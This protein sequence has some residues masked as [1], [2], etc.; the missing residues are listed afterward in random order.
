MNPIKV[1]ERKSQIIRS[2]HV[3]SL[4]REYVSGVV[5]CHRND[6]YTER[7]PK[8]S[9]WL[10]PLLSGCLRSLHHTD[11]RFRDAQPQFPPIRNQLHSWPLKNAGELKRLPALVTLQGDA[12]ASQLLL[13]IRLE[14][15]DDAAD[16]VFDA[17]FA[18][19]SPK[20]HGAPEGAA[21]GLMRFELPLCVSGQ[22]DEVVPGKHLLRG[23]THKAREGE[24]LLQQVQLGLNGKCAE[25]RL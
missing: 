18:H 5:Y 25:L 21:G 20:Q 12:G 24:V 7:G 11:S 6:S 19:A 14:D 22:P 16:A 9:I 10:R 1:L 15:D 8:Y 4:L 3:F 13:V 2:L 17:G 23:G